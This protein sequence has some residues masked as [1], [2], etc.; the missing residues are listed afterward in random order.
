MDEYHAPTAVCSWKHYPEKL[1]VPSTYTREQR[2]EIYDN[3]VK[4]TVKAG[5]LLAY[6]MRTFHR[7]TPFLADAGRIVAFVTYAPAAW[8][9]LGIVGWS[10]EAI[11]PAFREWIQRATPEERTLL[12]F[13]APGHE[14][15]T[16]ETLDGVGGRYPKMDL[17]PYRSARL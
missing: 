12:G 17:S 11:R 1:R 14:Y 6:S 2:P 8:K 13:P 7:G 16:D 10:R 15:W 4:V 5:S 9:W 3:E